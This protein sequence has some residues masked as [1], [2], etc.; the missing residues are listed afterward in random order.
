MGLAFEPSLAARVI[1]RDLGGDITRT[2]RDARIAF[3]STADLDKGKR[4][5]FADRDG[6]NPDAAAGSLSS[7]AN[8]VARRTW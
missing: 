7:R 8:P 1:K 6:R 2:E 3:V 5:L 4:S